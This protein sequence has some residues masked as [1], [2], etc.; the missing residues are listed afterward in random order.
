MSSHLQAAENKIIT[1]IIDRLTADHI[2]LKTI[3]D[4]S[5]DRL[6]KSNGEGWDQL[7]ERVVKLQSAYDD[8]TDILTALRFI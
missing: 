6:D 7:Q 1:G 4:A 5:D 8:I 3:L 2:K